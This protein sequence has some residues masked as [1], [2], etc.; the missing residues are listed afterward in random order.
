MLRIERLD[1]A[2][3]V[4]RDVKKRLAAFFD[5]AT[6]GVDTRG[7]PLGAN[8]SEEDIALA[9]LDVPQLE[10]IVDVK[11]REQVTG[12]GERPWPASL[13]PTEIVVLADDPVRIQFETAE[14][15][16]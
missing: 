12:V 4:G 11:R 15:A 10:S 5:T 8:P 9:L 1:S 16:A 13:K 6:G 3:A 14:A 2:G 7:W